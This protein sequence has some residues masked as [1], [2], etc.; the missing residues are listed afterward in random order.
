MS[1]QQEL[2]R[3]RFHPSSILYRFSILMM[4]VG[5][6]L[7]G[8]Y[9]AYDS[10]GALAP[11]IIEDMQIGREQ[12][13]M[14]YSFY[15]WPNVVMVFIGGFLID[16]FGT[17]K[18]SL[19]FSGLIVL[20][21]SLVAAA[22]LFW[23]MLVG[24]TIFGIG[25]ESLIICQ[26][27]ILAKWFKGKELAF[28]FGLALTFMRLGTLFSFNTEAWIA[29]YF[30]SWRMALW[31]AAFLCVLSLLCNL[32]YVF[33]EQRVRD[34]VR[35]SEG[36]AGDK[37]VLSDIRRFGPSFWFITLLCVTFYSAI[38]PF[39][40]FSTDFFHT[41]WGYSVITAGRITSIIIFASMILSP[42]LGAVVDKIGRRG[43][44]MIV[45]S[46]M[47]IPCYLVM[48]FTE[49]TP[50]APMVM[51]GLAF[52]LVPAAMWPAVP[53]IVEEKSVGTAFGL[54][55]MIQNFGLA[56]FPWLIGRVRDTTGSYT[57]AMVMLASLGLL[58]FI[59]AIL[60]KRADAKVGG[61]LERAELLRAAQG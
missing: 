48:G 58:G 9:F 8:N 60:L 33:L 4:F 10:I 18:M 55:T 52:S 53:L 3:G 44:M 31:A 14:M 43:T 21:A 51:L 28:A 20:G 49:L 61:G 56:A 45:G 47:M 6:M 30:G 19:V 36:A 25:A 5:L 1:E 13:G 42:I 22:P 46:L 26:S 39:T 2:T 32:V 11:L 41:K 57:L 59:F 54:M 16:R 50:I 12:I 40:A 7:V 15:S 29:Q 17:R 35:L 37:I 27:A 24:R 34:R 23:L 38:F